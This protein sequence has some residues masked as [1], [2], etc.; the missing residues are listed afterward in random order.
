ML[1]ECYLR[2]CTEF[3]I[4]ISV[5]CSILRCLCAI[6]VHSCCL[7]VI[8][9]RYVYDAHELSTMPCLQIINVSHSSVASFLNIVPQ[10]YVSYLLNAFQFLNKALLF[11][12]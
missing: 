4:V 6:L 1:S 9:Y 2:T 10:L 11:T 8:Y 3:L 7:S 12:L 5:T